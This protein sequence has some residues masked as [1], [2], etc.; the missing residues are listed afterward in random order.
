[1]T[2]QDKTD[3]LYHPETVHNLYCHCC[4][5]EGGVQR[6]LQTYHRSV[7]SIPRNNAANWHKQRLEMMLSK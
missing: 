5:L 1:M 6:A 4:E 3:Q 7:R 2:S